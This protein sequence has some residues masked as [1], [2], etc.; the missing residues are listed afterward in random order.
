ML[1]SYFECKGTQVKVVGGVLGVVG[2]AVVDAD[3]AEDALDEGAEFSVPS[4]EEGKYVSP[5]LF[6]FAPTVPV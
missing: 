6:T 4:A 5:F 2:V 3:V 1:M